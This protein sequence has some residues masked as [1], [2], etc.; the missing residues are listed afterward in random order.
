M[1]EKSRKRKQNRPHKFQMPLLPQNLITS[2]NQE[3]LSPT[4]KVRK[5]EEER[6][7]EEKKNAKEVL[8]LL[9]KKKKLPKV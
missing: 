6:E 2:Y 7:E 4:K 5:L 1:L 9:E 8:S 3:S